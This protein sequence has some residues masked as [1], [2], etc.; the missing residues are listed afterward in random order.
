MVSISVSHVFEKL[1]KLTRDGNSDAPLV[2]NLDLELLVV[3]N[4]IIERKLYALFK[5]ENGETLVLLGGFL[6][7]D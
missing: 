5:L 2:L 7:S 6:A 3:V 4:E 1:W